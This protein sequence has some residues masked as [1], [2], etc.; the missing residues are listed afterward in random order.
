MQ[1]KSIK[2]KNLCSYLGLVF[3]FQWFLLDPDL[4]HLIRIQIQGN[5][6]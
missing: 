3:C 4:Y 2:N 6:C 5:A 1:I